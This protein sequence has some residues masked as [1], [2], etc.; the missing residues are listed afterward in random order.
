MISEIRQSLGQHKF[1]SMYEHFIYLRTYARW[2]N[3]TER[4]ETWIE[5]VMR[6]TE[7]IVELTN[8]RLGIEAYRAIALSIYKHETVPSMRLLWSAGDCVRKNG[9]TAYNCAYQTISDVRSFSESL[10]ILMSGAGDGYSV[11]K[12]FVNQL[13]L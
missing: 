11:E 9:V 2:D 1:P 8:G 13:T 7:Y 4:R 5:T 10:S 12:R 3:N 6:Y